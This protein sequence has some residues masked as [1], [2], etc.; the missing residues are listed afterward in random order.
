MP[1]VSVAKPIVGMKGRWQCTPRATY[2]CGIHKLLNTSQEIHMKRIYLVTISQTIE[3]VASDEDEARIVA[4]MSYDFA[5][6]HFEVEIEEP[7]EGRMSDAD[8]S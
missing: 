8:Y 3:V 2:I 7:Q 4:A 6:S 1:S 5:N